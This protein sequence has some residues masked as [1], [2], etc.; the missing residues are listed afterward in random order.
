VPDDVAA[1][2][3][4]YD[5]MIMLGGPSAVSNDVAAM[6]PCPPP[7]LPVPAEAPRATISATVSFSGG[8]RGWAAYLGLHDAN[9][10]AVAMG[11]QSDQFDPPSGGRPFVHANYVNATDAGQGTGFHHLYGGDAMTPNETHN[12]EV[13]YFDGARKAMFF[14][15]GVG[16]LQVPIKMSGRLFFQTEVNCAQN[17]DSVDAHYTN[18]RIGGTVPSGNGHGTTVEPNG[19]WNTTSFDFWHLDMQ[20]TNSP[21]VQGANMHGFGTIS[22]M[23]PGTDWHTIETYN[24]GQYAGRPAGAIGMIAEYWFGQ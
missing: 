18:V 24:H 6:K 23:P 19:T 21:T 8:G 13:R 4:G 9:G 22:G 12:W 16:L 5:H 3:R 7:G 15:D 14:L 20:Q 17:G 10:N 2:L 1:E 11:A